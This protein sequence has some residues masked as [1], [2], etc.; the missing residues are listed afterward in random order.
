MFARTFW[1]IALT[2]C[3]AALAGCDG[4]V[5]R[6][7][8]ASPASGGSNTASDVE[9]PSSAPPTA[10]KEP[11]PIDCWV[12]VEDFNVELA[13]FETVFWEANDTA[14]LR[15]LI[16][17]SSFVEGKRVLEIGTGTGLI[18]LCCL[19]SGAAQV[20][21]T[22]INP[23]AIA[24]ARYNARGLELDARFETRLVPR[25]QPSAFSVVGEHE[26]FDLI[27][28]NPPWEDNVPLSIDKY[29]FYDPDFGLLRSLT[30]GLRDHLEPGGKA[31]LA[32]GNVTAVQELHRLAEVHKLDVRQLDDRD[33]NSLPENFLPGMLLE[34]TPR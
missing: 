25:D 2:L 18:S 31:L 23:A 1:E 10:E 30:A 15:R 21:A 26:R 14:S 6:R 16:R 28:S 3:A 5:E 20:V 32:Y 29:A 22:D 24:N 8:N 7:S 12:E 33:L 11:P 17:E 13:K 34:V 27:V 19:R 4:M 9:M